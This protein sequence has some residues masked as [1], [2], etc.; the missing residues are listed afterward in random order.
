M[1]NN[2]LVYVIFCLFVVNAI[3]IPE[4]TNNKNKS[5][6]EEGLGQKANRYLK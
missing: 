1:F 3:V 5:Y 2:I 6:K 4:N